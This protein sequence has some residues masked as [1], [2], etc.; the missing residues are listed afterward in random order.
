MKLCKEISIYLKRH[1]EGYIDGYYPSVRDASSY[2]AHEFIEKGVCSFTLTSIDD[3]G[4]PS[5]VVA[6]LEILQKE[7]KPYP[8]K[9]IGHIKY[10]K[11]QLL[12]ST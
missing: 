3:I 1:R 11:P 4:G 8:L 12:F 6:V 2:L 9:G 7:K 10:L 5:E